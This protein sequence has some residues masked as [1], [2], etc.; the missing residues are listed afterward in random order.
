MPVWSPVRGR[1]VARILLQSTSKSNHN[2]HLV[3]SLDLANYRGRCD[4]DI[5]I[6]GRCVLGV[7]WGRRE[8]TK[9]PSTCLF[10]SGDC[11]TRTTPRRPTT[12]PFRLMDESGFPICLATF[13]ITEHAYWDGSDS[14]QFQSRRTHTQTMWT[15]ALAD[16]GWLKLGSSTSESCGFHFRRIPYS[17][18]V[19][20]C[21]SGGT[22]GGTRDEING[23]TPMM[24]APRSIFN[25]FCILQTV[26]HYESETAIIFAKLARSKHICWQF[27]GISIHP[28]ELPGIRYRRV[29]ELPIP[30]VQLPCL[31]QSAIGTLFGVTAQG[32]S[33][34]RK[35]K[36]STW[37][38]RLSKVS[39][40]AVYLAPS[41]KLYV[42]T[43]VVVRES[44]NSRT[45][46]PA[47]PGAA[48][49]V[50][51]PDIK[52]AESVGSP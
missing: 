27:D 37:K 18:P 7:V 47:W 46:G 34:P 12:S 52:H 8:G 41:S 16:F 24:C 39:P 4:E 48:L 42:Q 44:Q 1:W 30:L 49:I 14:N 31:E 23:R 26:S 45:S 36:H 51:L 28:N 11:A 3:R 2:F 38:L 20:W 22:S 40:I 10:G 29:V 25:A 15:L 9:S 32:A 35:G 50:P 5:R 17:S 43:H 19:H 21:S 13:P 33:Q 6:I